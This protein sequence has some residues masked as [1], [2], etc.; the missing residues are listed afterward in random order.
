MN[1]QEVDNDANNTTNSFQ[2]REHGLLHHRI[3]HKAARPLIFMGYFDIDLEKARSNVN[4]SRAV[5]LYEF[6]LSRSLTRRIHVFQDP[7]IGQSERRDN[8]QLILDNVGL[9][10][11]S[12]SKLMHQQCKTDDA[13]PTLGKKL[14][15]NSS[16][17]LL[18]K[19]GLEDDASRHSSSKAAAK[20]QKDFD[21]TAKAEK[22]KHT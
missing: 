17:V 20:H 18:T 21:K 7:L 22:H 3:S 11:S 4:I 16:A 13:N 8:Q 12:I 6:I 9:T 5:P 1:D 2:S 15:N 10:S 19:I 14:A